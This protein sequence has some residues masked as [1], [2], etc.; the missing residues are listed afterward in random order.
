[1]GRCSPGLPGL[2]S[3]GDERL[4][5]LKSQFVSALLFILTVAAVS[6]AIVNC[7]QQSLYHLPE[8]GV[9]WVDRGTAPGGG[10]VTALHIIRGSQADH[11]G[12][13]T[14]DVLLEIDGGKIAS[15]IDVPQSLQRVG[16]WRN[17]KYLVRRGGVEV[18]APVI[19]GESV[20]DRAI[21]YQY[22]VG[23]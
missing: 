18:T 2:A 13:R 22:A 20:P 1:M 19:V 14:G 3:S 17:V 21:Y 12:I 4:R 9:A 15:A 16:P 5:D 7:R 8:D 6:C 23:V 11:A 10:S